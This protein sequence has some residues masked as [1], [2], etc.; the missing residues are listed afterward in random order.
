MILVLA[1]TQD[2]RQLAA[3]IMQ[4]GYQAIVSVVSRYGKELA[5]KS[6]LIVNV[7]NLI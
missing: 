2:G 4:A 5:S 3:C 7:D 6:N 1:G